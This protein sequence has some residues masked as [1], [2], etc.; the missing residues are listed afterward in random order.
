MKKVLGFSLLVFVLIWA[1][2]LVIGDDISLNTF[3]EW[4]QTRDE[5]REFE[6]TDIEATDKEISIAKSHLKGE[7]WIYEEIETTQGLKQISFN[8]GEKSAEVIFNSEGKVV[9]SDMEAED[10][11]DGSQLVFL[12]EREA[13]QKAKAALP[14]STWNL[15]S[16]AV[17]K[18][19]YN[20]ELSS[21]K[22]RA[23]V[24]VDGSS[25]KIVRKK[26]TVK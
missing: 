14:N 7:S 4:I 26:L 2:F 17:L 16:T 5:G 10:L 23:Y 21:Q 3:G 18:G 11:S 12:E 1:G 6:K 8:D 22:Y 15:E 19:N 20:I 9:E 24:K 25:G 13:I